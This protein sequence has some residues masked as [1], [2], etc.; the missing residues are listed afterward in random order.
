MAH[1]LDGSRTSQGYRP[2]IRGG[3]HGHWEGNDLVVDTIGYNDKTMLSHFIGHSKS[4]AFRLV[5]HFRLLDK[6]NMVIE[7]TYYDPKLGRQI[8][9]GVQEFYHRAPMENFREYICSPRENQA[10][11]NVV[12]AAG[13]RCH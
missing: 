10:F 2:D 5:E 1:L 9:A 3:F 8:L 6:N 12:I 11:D 13:E 7:M 4:D